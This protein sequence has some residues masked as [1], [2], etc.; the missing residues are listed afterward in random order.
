MCKCDIDFYFFNKILLKN[1]LVFY[2]Y[3]TQRGG[4]ESLTCILFEMTFQ[5]TLKLVTFEI[6]FLLLVMIIF[7]PITIFFFLFLKPITFLRIKY[8]KY[9][10]IHSINISAVNSSYL[11]AAIRSL[12]IIST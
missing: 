4:G 7:S 6:K 10:E 8:I 1:L 12:K 11:I 5:I 2:G 3:I 9:C